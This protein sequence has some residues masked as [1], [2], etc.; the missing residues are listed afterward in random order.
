MISI[1]ITSIYVDDQAKALE[2]YTKKLGFITQLDV[3]TGEY[4]W[5]TVSSPAD[6]DGVQVLLEPDQHPAAKAYKAALVEDGIPFAQLA[7]DDIDAEVARM[8]DVGVRFTQDVTD[9]GTV[10]VAVFDDTCGNLIQLAMT[11]E[12]VA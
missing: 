3:P 10:A 9:Y 12:H 2:F 11:K 6:P 4:R 8:K 5:L 1:K 7:V